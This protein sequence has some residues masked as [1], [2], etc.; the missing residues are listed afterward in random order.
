MMVWQ[1]E[2]PN[3]WSKEGGPLSYA[4]VVR[5]ETELAATNGPESPR[6]EF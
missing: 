6:Q 4:E 5:M 3:R 1:A 2:D